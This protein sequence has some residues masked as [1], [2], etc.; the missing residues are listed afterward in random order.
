MGIRYHNIKDSNWKLNS[1]K[2][3]YE[4]DTIQK[5]WSVYN[6]INSF[7]SAMFFLMKGNI[8]PTWEDKR[9][10]NGGS[11]S[12]KI[13]KKKTLE[14]WLEVMM[15]VIGNYLFDNNDRINGVTLNPKLSSSVIKIWVDYSINNIELLK[16]KH[17][18]MFID[19]SL[20]FLNHIKLNFNK[21][22]N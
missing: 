14:I 18:I 17:K 12:F 7:D 15:G 10:A 21:I 13:S 11:W 5:F 8:L 2:K 1:Y 9:N 4:I 6:N 3:I 22:E 16:F 19:N 20:A